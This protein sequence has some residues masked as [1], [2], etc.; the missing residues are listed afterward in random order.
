MSTRSTANH[1]AACQEKNPVSRRISLMFEHP[2]C[3][4][5]VVDVHLPLPDLVE[6]SAETA[7]DRVRPACPICKQSMQYVGWGFS[8]IDEENEPNPIP[9][10]PNNPIGPASANQDEGHDYHTPRLDAFL[11]S[12]PIAPTS[13]LIWYATHG[14]RDRVLEPKP[15]GGHDDDYRATR[16]ADHAVCAEIDRR[17]PIPRRMR[18]SAAGHSPIAT[19][20]MARI[21]GCTCGWKTLPGT[22]DSDTE[23]TR[24][25]IVIRAL[26]RSP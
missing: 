5:V 8:D 24:H 21:T 15:W 14:S 19:A 7:A 4:D 11:K 2:S 3:N 12:L 22:T 23:F 9:D 1:D 6:E 16:A 10:H 18:S 26:K 13:S 17:L 20:D 25:V